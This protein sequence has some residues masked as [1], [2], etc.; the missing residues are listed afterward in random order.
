M[1]KSRN[2]SLEFSDQLKYAGLH[3][4]Y[5]YRF[6]KTRKWRFDWCFPWKMLAIE[7]E[8]GIWGATAGRH[9]RGAGFLKDCEKYNEAA[10]LGWRIIRITDLHVRNGEGLRWVMEGLKDE[11]A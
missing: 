11:I 10:I 1:P 2:W 5:E 7:F 8:G 3:P 9:N 4:V 6:H